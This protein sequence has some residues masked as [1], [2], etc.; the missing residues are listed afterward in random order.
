MNS[1]Q[2]VRRFL[3]PSLVITMVLVAAF[4]WL[5]TPAQDE[6]RELANPDARQPRQRVPAKN[7]A[8]PSRGNVG[9]EANAASEPASSGGAVQAAGSRAPGA[10]VDPSPSAYATND[11]WRATPAPCWKLR[12]TAPEDFA[13]E[14]DSSAYTAGKSSVSLAS[15]RNT[16]GWGTLYQFADAK[17]LQGRRIEF[18]ADIRTSDV[19]RQAN[20]FVRAD[21]EKGNAVA[22]DTMW[23]SY[24]EDRRDDRL[25]NRTITGDSDWTTRH[26]VLDIPANAAVISYGVAL[27]GSGRVW[28]DNA[29][30]ELVAPDTPI[31]G[32][33]RSAGMLAENGMFVPDHLLPAPKNLDFETGGFDG[34][35]SR[36]AA[37]HR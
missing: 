5:R 18:S 10:S 29:Q 8:E 15:L 9:S 28:I 20:L 27:L 19:Q 2:I 3:V 23:Y 14:V 11:R 26:I 1:R 31:T 7:P 21:D 17:P 25:V 13:V 24:T 16:F 37:D 34:E 36:A 35:C 32:L 30:F 6:G 33:V 4:L 12:G 22:M